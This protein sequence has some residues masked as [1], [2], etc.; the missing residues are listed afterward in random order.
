LAALQEAAALVSTLTSQLD[1]LESE[2]SKL[3]RAG[4]SEELD[5]RQYSLRCR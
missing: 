2:I 3:S 1:S 5:V 4:E